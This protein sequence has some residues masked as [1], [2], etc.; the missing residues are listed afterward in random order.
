MCLCLR[1][2]HNR[3][4]LTAL[5]ARCLG[6]CHDFTAGRCFRGG[7]C[8]FSHPASMDGIGMGMMGAGMMGA[9]AMGGG[10]PVRALTPNRARRPVLG[11]SR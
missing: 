7:A 4:L 5:P 8:K 11:R 1:A 6:V 2:A 9:P 10:P 3:S